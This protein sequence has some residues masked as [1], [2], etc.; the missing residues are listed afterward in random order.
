MATIPAGTI[1]II[2]IVADNFPDAA[3]HF[4]PGGNTQIVVPEVKAFPFE[5]CPLSG[6]KGG[7]TQI[8][9][10]SVDRILWFSK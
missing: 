5:E 1:A 3:G 6:G 2:G 8:E 9:I 4:R 10:Q 7:V